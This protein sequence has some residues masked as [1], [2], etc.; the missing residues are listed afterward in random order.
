MIMVKGT[1]LQNMVY[2][3]SDL[4]VLLSLYNSASHMTWLGGKMHAAGLIL[5]VMWELRKSQLSK[6]AEKLEIS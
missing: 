2:F 4:M 3:N 6:D 5:E 1:S